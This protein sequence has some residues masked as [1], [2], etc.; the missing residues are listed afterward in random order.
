LHIDRERTKGGDLS[1]REKSLGDLLNCEIRAEAFE[2][3]TDLATV[4]DSIEG[5]PVRVGHVE[6]GYIP[7]RLPCQRRLSMRAVAESQARWFR[8]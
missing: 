6:A 7:A 5:K 2:I 8:L 1:G 4:G 3:D